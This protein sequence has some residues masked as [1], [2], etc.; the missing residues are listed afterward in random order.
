[1]HIPLRYYWQQLKDIVYR[2]FHWTPNILSTKEA[3]DFI[4]ENHASLSRFGDGELKVM[5][6]GDI[7]FQP[8]HPLLQQ[9]LR[10]VIQ[11][12]ELLVGIPDV[13]EN[14]GRYCP[15]DQKFWRYHLCWN[16]SRW[17]SLLK[18]EQKYVSTFLSRFYSIDYDCRKAELRLT[19]L[20]RLWRDRDI[21]IIEGQDSKLGVGNDLFSC[22]KSIRR[23]LCPSK[24]AF[25]HYDSIVEAA[26]SHTSPTDLII[27]ALGPTASVLSYD[28]H[29][30]GF[31]A[32]DLG[33]IDIEYEWYLMKATQKEPIRG[34]F[35]NEAY[36]ESRIEH[37][38]V[39]QIK[40][41]VYLNQIVCSIL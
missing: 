17:F 13:F 24:N 1:M 12:Q 7:N 2:H 15:F 20:K 31:Q 8:A 10:E 38:V 5:Y 21:L 6:G 33:H 16:R 11:S 35:S 29:K 18:A 19:E 22:A 26:K 25:A 14:L 34:K 32:L 39:G 40:D 36:L 9:R 3:V 41:S 4:I 30:S 27:L 23:I 37:E 28:L